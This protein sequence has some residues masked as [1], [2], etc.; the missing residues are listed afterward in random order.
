MSP[1]L[2]RH[3]ARALQVV[4][5]LIGLATLTFL[6]WEP[7]LEGRNVHATPFEIY[8]H[9]PFLAYVYVGSTP[10]FLA[11]H[12]AFGLFGHTAQTGAFSSATVTALHGIRRCALTLLAFVAGS[13][14]FIVLL[15]DQE[16]RPAGFMLCLLGSIFAGALA[17]LAAVLARRLQAK[18]DRPEGRGR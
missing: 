7:H 2:K 11:L 3:T 1:A 9:D 8:F 15:G 6:L 14:I 10:F 16:D 12:R 18:L 13:S 17:A 4:T 5:V